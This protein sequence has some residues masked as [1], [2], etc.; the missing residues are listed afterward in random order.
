MVMA[1][2]PRDLP[3]LEL[4][5]GFRHLVQGIRSVDV[6][7]D[8]TGFDELREGVVLKGDDDERAP[9]TAMTA[10]GTRVQRCGWSVR[11]PE[12]TASAG[13]DALRG[14]GEDHEDQHQSGH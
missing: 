7:R 6:R 10:A 3:C 11:R 5:Q 2:S 9:V 12:M 1:T 4:P 8:L 13:G 14:A